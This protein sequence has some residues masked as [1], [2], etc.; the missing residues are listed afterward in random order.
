MEPR[1]GLDEME[2]TGAAFADA[3]CGMSDSTQRQPSPL[4]HLGQA[5]GGF[6]LNS[7]MV[8]APFFE[9]SI[10]QPLEAP[11]MLGFGMNVC[12]SSRHC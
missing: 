8:S 2:F 6:F 10:Q 4:P 7:A 5:L 12:Y 3:L 1:A 11:S 9:I